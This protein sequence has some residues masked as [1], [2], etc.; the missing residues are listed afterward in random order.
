MRF[1]LNLIKYLICMGVF[2]YTFVF[3]NKDSL[4]KLDFIKKEIQIFIDPWGRDSSSSPDHIIAFNKINNDSIFINTYKNAIL[5]EVI[6]EIIYFTDFYS[7][8][9]EYPIGERLFYFK[10]SF[11]YFKCKEKTNLIIGFVFLVI[12]IVFFALLFFD[13]SRNLNSELS[14]DFS[15]TSRI[16]VFISFMCFV[17]FGV[18]VGLYFKRVRENGFNVLG[19]QHG[20]YLYRNEIIETY[21]WASFTGKYEVIKSEMGF[22]YELDKVKSVY[23]KY[24][25]NKI[26]KHVNF[27][28]VNDFELYVKIMNHRISNKGA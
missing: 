1:C 11:S 6:D 23:S 20:I 28:G 4:L 21:P 5:P 17:F 8:S 10:S 27:I 16:Y 7:K 18:L 2:E 25:S 3:E 19:T 13:N 26:N 14:H 12:S 9:I 15:K 24:G 22:S